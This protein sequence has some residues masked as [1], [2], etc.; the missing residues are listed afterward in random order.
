MRS[1]AR[2]TSHFP[3]TAVFRAAERLG[4]GLGVGGDA[5]TM[6]IDYRHVAVGFGVGVG[7]GMSL[8][9]LLP[10][11]KQPRQQKARRQPPQPQQQLQTPS[12]HPAARYGMPQ[13]QTLRELDGFVAA[14]DGATRNPAWVLEHVTR[15]KMNGEAE[16]ANSMFYEDE[17]LDERLRNR[18]VDFRNSGY[19]RGHLAPAANHKGRQGAMDGTFCLSNISPQV[20]DGFN[21]DYWA[22]FEKFVKDVAK[23]ADDLY[24]V[25]GPLYLPSP[26]PPPPPPGADAKWRANHAYIGTPPSL[27]AVPTHFYK[28]VLADN[29]SGK[30]GPHRAAVAAFVMPNAAIDAQTPLEA[31]TV[32]LDALERAAGTSFFPGFVDQTRREALDKT[33]L[34]LQERGRGRQAL[35]G[36]QAAALLL[37][38][39]PPSSKEVN[40]APPP[41]L[42]PPRTTGGRG[43]VHLCEHV[44]CKLPKEK[45]WLEGGKKER[46]QLAASGRAASAPPPPPS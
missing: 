1:R 33:A 36:E 34:A 46:G 13:T 16:R 20:G 32:P 24:V 22:R 42:P 26:P 9:A 25:T 10:Q 11:Q 39:S 3:W 14:F 27:V 37:P 8:G 43:A 2:L 35:A 41:P 28:V 6:F 38:P 17:A 18:L 40:S 30:H 31:F 4:R 44:A 19:D 7:V 23:R 29:E 45:W 21:R 5:R 15:E 12:V